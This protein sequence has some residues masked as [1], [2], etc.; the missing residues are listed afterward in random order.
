M[1]KWYSH[2]GIIEMLL[3]RTGLIICQKYQLAWVFG[4]PNV[5]LK[6]ARA[7]GIICGL[8]LYGAECEVGYP[9]R[10]YF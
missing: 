1:L 5:N 9:L 6:G 7:L 10:M 2:D 8:V 4:W 3:N